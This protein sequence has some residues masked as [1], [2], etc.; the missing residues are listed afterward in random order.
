MHGLPRILPQ[1]PKSI[2]ERKILPVL[3]DA[4]KDLELLSL[5]LQSVFKTLDLV[6]NGKRAFSEQAIPALRR[7]FLEGQ[8]TKGQAHDRNT[9]KEGG[10][11][12]LLENMSTVKNN[13]T[14]KE[15]KDGEYSA[16]LMFQDDETNEA[17]TLFQYFTSPSS[18]LRTP[19]LTMPFKLSRLSSPASTSLLLRTSYSL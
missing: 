8:S 12:V 10:L 18:P 16:R 13:S 17:K 14:G 5:I 15:F 3:L 7:V 2:L 4:M 19:L 6:T 1:F 9:S 11:I